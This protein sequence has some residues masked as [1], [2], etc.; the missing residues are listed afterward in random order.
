MIRQVESPPPNLFES[1]GPR[2][3]SRGWVP[4]NR[5]E[6]AAAFILGTVYIVF[7][8]VAVVAAVQLKSGLRS[9]IPSPT[10]GVVIGVLAIAIVLV[11]AA[12]FFFLGGRIVVSVFRRTPNNRQHP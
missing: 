7:G 3:G 9:W 12:A 11:V 2:L 8:V 4:R 5:V 10:T 6:R 1:R